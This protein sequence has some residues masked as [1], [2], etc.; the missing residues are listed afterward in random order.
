MFKFPFN[1]NV[2]P[3]ISKEK[4]KLVKQTQEEVA[5]YSLTPRNLESREYKFFDRKIDIVTANSSPSEIDEYI[6]LLKVA[7]HINSKPQV[8]LKNSIYIA[9]SDNITKQFYIDDYYLIAKQMQNIR[10]LWNV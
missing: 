5:E 9:S 10:K 3:Y 7:D 1:A 4:N 2:H 8:A 6:R